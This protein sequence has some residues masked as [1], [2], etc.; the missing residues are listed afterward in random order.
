MNVMDRYFLKQPQ[1]IIVKV[2][3]SSMELEKKNSGKK[4]SEVHTYIYCLY[5][6]WES[7]NC[8]DLF[9]SGK[10]IQLTWYKFSTYLYQLQTRKYSVVLIRRNMVT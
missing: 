9:T 6:V 10:A 4:L 2:K 5:F 8:S 7:V 1:N 3:K